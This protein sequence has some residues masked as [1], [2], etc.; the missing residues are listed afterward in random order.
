MKTVVEVLLLCAQ[1]NIPMHGH[2][3][4]DSSTNRGNII[5]ILHTIASHDP[6]IQERL[7]GNRSSIYTTPPIQNLLLNIL[8]ECVC[9]IFF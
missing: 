7:T 4:S 6:V 1:Q 2:D 8:G 5:E 9:N 3:E